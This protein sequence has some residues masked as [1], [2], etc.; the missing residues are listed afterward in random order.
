M[1][2][3]DLVRFGYLA[4]RSAATIP[5]STSRGVLICQR[6]A[7]AQ[8]GCRHPVVS[9]EAHALHVRSERV[10]AESLA[11]RRVLPLPGTGCEFRRTL[12]E[13]GTASSLVA[14]AGF[15][16]AAFG[17]GPGRVALGTPL[18]CWTGLSRTRRH[19]QQGLD[20]ALSAITVIG[21]ETSTIELGAACSSHPHGAGTR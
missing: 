18:C 8:V 16:P 3:R 14:G 12:T 1:R 17:Y 20:L 6:S 19:S 2:G 7:G 15:E 10:G 9:V 21:Q 13:A 5:E 4:S 11:P